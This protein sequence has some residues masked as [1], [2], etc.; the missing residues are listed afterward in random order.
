MFPVNP[1]KLNERAWE[2][3]WDMGVNS[4]VFKVAPSTGSLNWIDCGV[5]ANRCAGG[6]GAGTQLAD[7]CLAGLGFAGIRPLVRDGWSGPCVYVQSDHPVA[8]CLASQY[9]GWQL[10]GE[11][12]FAMGSG[13]MRAAANRE[14]IFADIGYHETA[15]RVVGVL[16]SNQVPPTEIFEQI[17]A[18]CKVTPENVLLLGARTASLAGTIQ[19]VARSLETALHK[20]HALKFDLST[21]LSGFGVAPLAPIAKDD[22]TAIGWTNDAVLY[23]GEVTI[24]VNT[25]DDV[26]STIGPQVPSSASP[27]FGEPFGEIFNRYGGDFYKIDPLLFSPAVVTFVNLKS[28]RTHRFGKLRYDVLQHWSS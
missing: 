11:K 10:K 4:T 19:V 21:I 20:L 12:F 13:P 28:G 7:I 5:G 24:W 16:E 6:L 3:A 18:A 17:A 27:D 1:L 9:A 14:P 15:E 22:L 26:I 2:L 23:G 25:D 8:A